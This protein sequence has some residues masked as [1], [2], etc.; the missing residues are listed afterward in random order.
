MYDTGRIRQSLDSDWKAFEE[1]LK[2]ALDSP[3]V[4]LSALD[5]YVL[6]KPGKQLRPALT[7]CTARICGTPGPL[8]HAVAA[9]AEMIHTASLLHDDVADN[10]EMRRGILSV[11]KRFG[12]SESIILGDYWFARAFQ[13]LLQYEGMHLLPLYADAIEALSE[14]EMLQMEKSH[15]LD[16]TLDEYYT[17]CENKTV[18]LFQTSMIS[19]A[20]SVPQKETSSVYR[21]VFEKA[22]YHMGMAFQIHDD[23]MD[24]QPVVNSG[25]PAYQDITESKITLPLLGAL[26]H[27][28][29]G[30]F[31]YRIVDWIRN[32]EKGDNT[33]LERILGF[34]DQYD[35]M[36]YASRV[37]QHHMLQAQD[38]LRGLPDSQWKDYL[39]KISGK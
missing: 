36:G 2:T 5:A 31:R 35:G 24:Y 33:A 25:K 1:I 19:G 21:P 3:Y 14:G 28:G 17:I 11:H 37:L 26:A 38:Q 6:D 27:A 4:L 30:H 8:S 18:S 32:L 12:A 22:A 23:M 15:T 13:I 7:L 9:V 16:L 29:D 39:L 34:I 20:L 10:A